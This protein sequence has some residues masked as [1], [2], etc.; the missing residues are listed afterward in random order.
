MRTVTG[1]GDPLGGDPL[2]QDISRRL[3]G[4]RRRLLGWE[5]YVRTAVLLPLVKVGGAW[6]LLFEVRSATLRRQP[7]EV[8]F[9]GGHL[10]AGDQDPQAAAVRETG[11]EL[12]LPTEDVK[13]LGALDV[14]ITPWRLIVYPYVGVLADAARIRPARDEIARVFTVRL[15]EVAAARPEVHEIYV[16]VFPRDDFPFHRIPGGRNYPWRTAVHP[17][18]F[19]DF[20]GHV[21]WGLTA[22]ILDH[23]R[24]L[25]LLEG[26]GGDQAREEGELPWLQP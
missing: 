1:G 13:V 18:L 19:F 15:Q 2:L 11:E 7:G 9:P 22:R 16:R 20:G 24:T 23:F 5:Q 25:C 17:E 8:C 26:P 4:R 3:V 14:L 12:N 21:V 6:H 10:E